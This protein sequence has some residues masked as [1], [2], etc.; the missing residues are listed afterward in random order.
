MLKNRSLALILVLVLLMSAAFI[1]CGTKK[2]EQGSTTTAQVTTEAL[3][4]VIPEI[5]I[6][7]TD[8][9]DFG[10]ADDSVIGLWLEQKYKVK[11]KI[12]R[13]PS[14]QRAVKV[15]LLIAA[16]EMPDVMYAGQD[17]FTVKSLYDQNALG[18]LKKEDIQK[19]APLLY[20]ALAKISAD[21][22]YDTYFATTIDGKNYGIPSPWVGGLSFDTGV[23]GRVWRM[24]LV[25]ELGINDVP[26]TIADMEEIGKRLKAKSPDSYML[27]ARGKDAYSQSFTDIYGAFGYRPDT[28][29]Y[30]DGKI[31]YSSIMP[32]TK[33]AVALLADWYKKGYID[34]EWITGAYADLTKKF[35]SGTNLS[36]AWGHA[37]FG[38]PYMTYEGYYTLAK[39]AKPDAEVVFAPWVKGPSGR[40]AWPGGS[41]YNNQSATVFSK[42]MASD[43]VKVAKFLKMVEDRS[44]DEETYLTV[45]YGIKDVHYTL[46]P[47]KGPTVTDQKYTT[48]EAKNQ[49]GM[50]LFG[51]ILNTG[52]VVK[53]LSNKLI[54]ADQRKENE[55]CVSEQAKYPDVFNIQNFYTNLDIAQKP[56]E[57][58]NEYMPVKTI[59]QEYI[60][61]IILGSKPISAFDEMVQKWLD[62]GGQ[63]RT[64]FI[65][66]ENMKYVKK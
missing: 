50:F 20:D 54:S 48:D 15:G 59:P 44:F 6:A 3:P 58:E 10:V 8:Q 66:K 13:I 42:E 38:N 46:D 35:M 43:P 65:N 28:W 31:V 23:Y 27:S 36:F 4:E 56:A 63:K 17:N 51:F 33:E 60:D 29:I 19:N 2:A 62:G 11:F 45:S 18:E 22:K 16:N 34:P 30:K 47:V 14:D 9:R 25:K 52:D 12:V 41:P 39:A 21:Y 37:S 53:P 55:W 32:E 7:T 24:D 57:L 26:K 1:G 49:I 61:A 5:S 40:S 64:D